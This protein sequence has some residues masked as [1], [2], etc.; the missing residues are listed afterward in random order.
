MLTFPQFAERRKPYVG[1]VQV[2]EADYT[3]TQSVRVLSGEAALSEL[4]A[5]PQ[6]KKAP[7]KKERTQG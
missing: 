6:K 1:L 5:T 2:K 3:R 7:R 4:G